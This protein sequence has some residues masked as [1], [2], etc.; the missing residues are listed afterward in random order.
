[1]QKRPWTSISSRSETHDGDRRGAELR[2]ANTGQI[3]LRPVL[4]F[5]LN[6]IPA[7]R[8]VSPQ[9]ISGLEPYSALPT[10]T[11]TTTDH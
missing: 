6:L 8:N 11:A 1:M 3:T 4:I 7:L 5:G 10:V 9:L 2:W